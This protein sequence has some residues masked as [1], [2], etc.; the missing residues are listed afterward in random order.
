MPPRSAAG[1]SA[2]VKEVR[3]KVV[4]VQAP[5]PIVHQLYGALLLWVRG[6]VSLPSVFWV[7]LPL[8]EVDAWETTC[9]RKFSKVF[10]S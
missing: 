6:A 8:S 1:G 9:M 5:V 10:R 4:V 7:L 2:G 3:G